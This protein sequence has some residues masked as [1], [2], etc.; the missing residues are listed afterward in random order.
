MMAQLTELVKTL[1][2]YRKVLRFYKK[3][4]KYRYNIYIFYNSWWLEK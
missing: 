1:T 3:K 4:K 2:V